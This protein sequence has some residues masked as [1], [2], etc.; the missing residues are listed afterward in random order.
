MPLGMTV[1]QSGVAGEEMTRRDAVFR[2]R[3]G[4]TTFVE[5]AY[6]DTRAGGGGRTWENEK[7]LSRKTGGGRRLPACFFT[8]TTGVILP[9]PLLLKATRSVFSKTQSPEAKLK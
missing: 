6:A 9:P 7:Q 2:K 5:R 8:S 3:K 1:L 4:P